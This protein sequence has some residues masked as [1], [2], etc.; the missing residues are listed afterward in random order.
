MKPIL[1]LAA[2]SLLVCSL[3]SGCVS[4][5]KYNEMS[6]QYNNLKADFESTEFRLNEC[7]SEKERQTA[8]VR[9][10]EDKLK[11]AGGGKMVDQLADISIINPTQSESVKASLEKIN[12][13]NSGTSLNDRLAA[14]LK[15]T[16]SSND[17]DNVNIKV[18]G[19]AVLI[20]L[21]DETLFQSGSYKIS[22]EA[23]KVLAS[24]AQ[25]I[26]SQPDLV[27]MVEGH[28]DDRNV[29]GGT[30]R[31]N[32]DLSVLRA[33]TVVF[34]LQKTY[35]LDPSRLIAAGRAEFLPIGDNNTVE[36]RSKNRRTR[37]L[38]MPRFDQYLKAIE[39]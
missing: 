16:I 6:T 34:E 24:V 37:I 12:N 4:S 13:S 5:K 21:F 10:L 31:N 30:I 27:C 22:P 29:S 2:G 32:W 25:V 15:G 20:S 3:N 38:I 36:G 17:I 8:K 9:E 19:G 7:I 35:G 26:K 1:T 14:T 28:T 23:S 11:T 18:E 39:P 33:S